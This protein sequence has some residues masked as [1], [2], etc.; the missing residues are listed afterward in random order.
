MARILN[1]LIAFDR[2]VNALIGGDD[3]ETLSSVAYRINR[4]SG[5][6]KW[7]KKFIETLFFWEPDHCKNAYHY[8]R[9]SNSDMKK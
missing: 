6:F 3:R 5:N 2:G 8:D 9:R 4:D 7:T 1:F